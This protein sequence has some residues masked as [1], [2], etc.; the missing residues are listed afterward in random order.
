MVVGGLVVVERL[1]AHLLRNSKLLAGL[2]ELIERIVLLL[3]GQFAP[4]LG[5]GVVHVRK[6]GFGD[7]ADGFGTAETLLAH[8]GAPRYGVAV[9][10]R[11]VDDGHHLVERQVVDRAPH[12]VVGNLDD[13]L[14]IERMMREGGDV[15]VVVHVDRQRC[16]ERPGRILLALVGECFGHPAEI[17]VEDGVEAAFPCRRKRFVRGFAAGCDHG[18]EVGLQHERQ[19]VEIGFLGAVVE[20]RIGL[21]RYDAVVLDSFGHVVRSAAL[22][23]VDLAVHADVF[24]GLVHERVAHDPHLGEVDRTAAGAQDLAFEEREGRVAPAG[25][26]AVLVLDRGHGDQPDVGESVSLRLGCGGSLRCGREGGAERKGCQQEFFHRLC[27]LGIGVRLLLRGRDDLPA[28]FE[29]QRLRLGA[30][31]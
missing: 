23:E 20:A 9:G 27:C 7:D 24:H 18:V 17:L 16:G 12:P 29:R 30:F 1:L 4:A 22:G 11:V 8:V 2:V 15:D 3:L 25:A 28:L 6:V 26:A 31:R 21:L 5:F 10:Q 14:R 13:E 19:F